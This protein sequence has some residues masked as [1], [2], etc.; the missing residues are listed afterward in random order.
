MN[1]GKASPRPRRAILSI[2]AFQDNPVGP[3]IW[4]RPRQGRRLGLPQRVGHQIRG[5]L[6]GLGVDGHRYHQKHVAP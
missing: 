3:E 6:E 5:P 4:I 2:P 1:D